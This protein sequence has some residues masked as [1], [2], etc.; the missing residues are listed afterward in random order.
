M[1]LAVE[2]LEEL[3]PYCLENK[4]RRREFISAVRCLPP[5]GLTWLLF[6]GYR[7]ALSGRSEQARQS[8]LQ[9]YFECRDPELRGRFHWAL[10]S[11]DRPYPRPA[12]LDELCQWLSGALHDGPAQTL[13]AGGP[14]E[15]AQELAELCQWLRSPVLEGQS[16]RE[17]LRDLL[18]GFE[19]VEL[20]LEKAPLPVEQ[21]FYRIF[22][23][24]KEARHHLS[25]R[26]IRVALRKKAKWWLASWDDE[27]SHPSA[28]PT[29][30][31]RAALLGGRVKLRIDPGFRLQVRCP[32]GASLSYQ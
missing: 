26:R 31:A 3:L 7:L 29:A 30:G 28:L 13:A 18:A 9:G 15:L 19:S 1:D 20:S 6:D 22:Q 21:L 32:R 12:D 5:R 25:P 11:L 27:I 17:A 16:L 14:R 2:H 8:F 4:R 23:E 24:L 10:L